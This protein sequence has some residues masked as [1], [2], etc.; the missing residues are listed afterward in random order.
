[1]LS[2]AVWLGRQEAHTCHLYGGG[3]HSPLLIPFPR[4][5]RALMAALIMGCLLMFP[6]GDAVAQEGDPL[7]IETDKSGAIVVEVDPRCSEVQLRGSEA[8]VLWGIDSSALTESMGIEYLLEADEFRIDTSKYPGGLDAGRFDSFVIKGSG[9][10]LDRPEPST[11]ST[12][13]SHSVLARDLRAGVYYHARV[14]IRTPK[15]WL[16]SQPVGFISSVCA[17]D[18]IEE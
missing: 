2:E 15:G 7:P 5:P 8:R 12:L 9:T 13:L 10:L 3:S 16:A 11:N 14:L 6:M 4:P 1:M 17:V 18:G